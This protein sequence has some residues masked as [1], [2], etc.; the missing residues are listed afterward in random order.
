VERIDHLK[1]ETMKLELSPYAVYVC[2][3]S[4]LFSASGMRV[5]GGP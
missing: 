1:A 4:T 5:I 3:P 2:K